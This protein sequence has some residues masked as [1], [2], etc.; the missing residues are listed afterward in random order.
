MPHDGP[1]DRG[2]APSPPRV[3][4]YEAAGHAGGYARTVD[5]ELDG[6]RH[7]VDTGFCAFDRR[8]CPRL[9]ALF[10]ALDVATV[11][12]EMSFSVRVTGRGTRAIEWAGDDLD[13]VFVQRRNVFD[14]RF[15]KMLADRVRLGRQLS[16]LA[17][18][19]SSAVDTWTVGEFLEANRYSHSFRDW[20]LLPMAAAI[21]SCSAAQVREFPLSTLVRSDGLQA[22]DRP[23]WTAVAGGSRRYVDRIVAALDDVLLE[24][25]VAGV[26]RVRSDG[27][28]KV[29]VRSAGGA[30]S[31]A[32]VVLACPSDQALALLEDADR[33]ERD[34]L[35]SIAYRQSH[36]VLHTDAALLPVDRRAWAAFNV[37]CGTASSGSDD[38]A[39]SVHHL[40]NKLQPLPF[41][42]P[43]IVS[44]DPAQ[45]PAASTIL[46][47]FD[48]SHPVFDGLAIRAQRR[49]SRIQGRGNIWYCGAWTGHGLHE[50]GSR[51]G[52]EVADAI[53]SRPSKARTAPSNPGLRSSAEAGSNPRSSEP[54]SPSRV[55]FGGG[56]P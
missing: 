37:R 6:V 11:A 36:A 51:S 24:T 40:V 56:L 1:G 47:E 15:P 20:Y 39:V 9:A 43:V 48:R 8:A 30:K 14:P 12:S 28:T 46:G 49:L 34:L 29:V 52:L 54:Q 4:L 53:V 2:E 35:R 27:E 42:R 18:E 23:R 5:V 38:G 32:H 16:A 55:L 13:S 33:D 7:P 50:D 17:R 41:E 45:R 10:E 21:W 22:A 3:T 26:A 19:G 31:Y 44:L 25:P